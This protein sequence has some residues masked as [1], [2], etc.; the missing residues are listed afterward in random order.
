MRGVVKTYLNSP[1]SYAKSG[2]YFPNLTLYRRPPKHPRGN[3]RYQLY[4]EFSGPKMLFGNNFDE[5]TE[6]DFET[7]VRVIIEKLYEMIGHMFFPDQIR[8]AL[9]SAWHPSKNIVFLDYTASQTILNTLAKL[10]V[11]RVYD[12]QKDRYRDGTVLHIHA[13]SIDISFYDKMADLRKAKKSERR[14]VEKDNQAQLEFLEPLDD[15]KPLE[16]FRYEIRLGKRDMI[17]RTYPDMKGWS[18]EEMFK[19]EHC[20]GLLQK[21]WHKITSSVDLLALDVDKPFELMQNYLADNPDKSLSKAMRGIL[22]LLVINQE[23]TTVLRNI[24]EAHYGKDAWYSL[25]KDIKSPEK[26]RYKAF[27]RIDEQLE[28]FTPTNVSQFKETIE[29]TIK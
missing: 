16:V 2:I 10:D 13:N 18:F 25:K 7:L 8:N 20:Q 9:V 6:K 5:L 26:Y 19:Q 3:T 4:V 21:H 27:Q 28:K 15:F 11:S 12:F 23:S 17:K 29:N 1:K 22:G 14:A 24:I